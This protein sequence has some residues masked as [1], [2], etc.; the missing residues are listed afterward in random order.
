MFA[1]EKN[2]IESIQKEWFIPHSLMKMLL[3]IATPQ[4]SMHAKR[5]HTCKKLINA[6]QEPTHKLHH[7]LQNTMLILSPGPGMVYPLPQVKS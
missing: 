7:S 2:L 4:P 6:I 3:F 5:I 1:H